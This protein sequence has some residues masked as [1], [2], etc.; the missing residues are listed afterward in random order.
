MTIQQRVIRRGPGRPIKTDTDGRK[1]APAINVIDEYYTDESVVILDKAKAAIG[2]AAE[3]YDFMYGSPN[4]TTTETLA[5]QGWEPVETTD[6]N[7]V[8]KQWRHRIDPLMRRVKGES[9]RRHKMA[10]EVARDQLRNT[11]N[12]VGEDGIT[13]ED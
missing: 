9:E 2:Q 4:P 11:L 1:Q 6:A 3:G 8:K 13:P 7:G 10:A 12:A 5:L